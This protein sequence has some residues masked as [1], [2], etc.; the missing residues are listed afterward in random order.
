M[1]KVCARGRMGAPGRPGLAERQS[2][3]GFNAYLPGAVPAWDF[4]GSVRQT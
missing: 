1:P 3:V 2:G 4:P